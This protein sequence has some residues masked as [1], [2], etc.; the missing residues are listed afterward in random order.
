MVEPMVH[1]TLP[2]VDRAGTPSVEDPMVQALV[3]RLGSKAPND[4]LID[5]DLGLLDFTAAE[6]EIICR[7]RS[8]L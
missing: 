5:D 4:D 7:M 8:R 2:E 6:F 1:S 3:A